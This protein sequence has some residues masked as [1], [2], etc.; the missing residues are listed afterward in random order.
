[1]TDTDHPFLSAVNETIAAVR[2]VASTPAVRARLRGVPLAAF[3]A[4]KRSGEVIPPL[5]DIKAAFPDITTS[6]AKAYVEIRSSPTGLRVQTLAGKYP[7]LFDSDFVGRTKGT[8]PVAYIASNAPDMTLARSV[9]SRGSPAAG[10][11]KSS[12]PPIQELVAENSPVADK[13]L[14]KV[15]ANRGAVAPHARNPLEKL[16]AEVLERRGY[17]ADVNPRTFGMTTEVTPKMSKGMKLLGSLP[18]IGAGIDVA[19]AAQD[20]IDGD[21]SDAAAHLGDAAIGFTGVGEVANL[22]ASTA[23]DSEGFVS[24]LEDEFYDD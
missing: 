18:F 2:T 20:A 12:V 22:I 7:D 5:D 15:L 3:N 13:E 1:M 4:L 6:E 24:L 11:V 16:G 8:T 23:T 17:Q 21:Y 19:M 10:K 14:S 9:M